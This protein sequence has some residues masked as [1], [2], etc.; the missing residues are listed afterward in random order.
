MGKAVAVRPAGDFAKPDS[1]VSVSIDPTTGLLAAPACPEKR[2]E[3]FISGTEP[4]EYCTVHGD[5][6]ESDEEDGE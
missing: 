5:D 3:F 4:N 2:D 1:V 6:A